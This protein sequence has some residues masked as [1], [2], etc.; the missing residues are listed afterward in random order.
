MNRFHD[1]NG[2]RLAFAVHN[3]NFIVRLVFISVIIKKVESGD[4]S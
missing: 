3:F 2:Y 4:L 1:F